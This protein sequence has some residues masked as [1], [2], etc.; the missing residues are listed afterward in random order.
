MKKL[1]LI[2]IVGITY[3]SCNSQNKNQTDTNN[4]KKIE[5]EYNSSRKKGTPTYT[6][7][8][9][10]VIEAMKK[11]K[12]NSHSYTDSQ[13]WRIKIVP[14]SYTKI[15]SQEQWNWTYEGKK[16]SVGQYYESYF[17]FT[18]RTG[19]YPAFFP[20]VLMS[21]SLKNK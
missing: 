14:N 17:R 18:E 15:Q 8:K 2:L 20:N 1:I 10:R 13:T 6:E 5:I 16:N 12:P 11:K 9:N 4:E 7:I 21:K 3:T 19:E